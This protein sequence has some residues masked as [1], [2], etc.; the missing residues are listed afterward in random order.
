MRLIWSLLDGHSVN[1]CFRLFA[2]MW[3]PPELHDDVVAEPESTSVF[4]LDMLARVMQERGTTRSGALVHT[5]DSGVV[6]VRRL[7]RAAAIG[8]CV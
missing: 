4:V 1:L 5:A 3:C 7:L 2:R 6:L 8:A